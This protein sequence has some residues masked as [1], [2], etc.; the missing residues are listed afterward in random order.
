VRIR[1]DDRFFVILD[2]E[3][4]IRAAGERRRVL[5][6]GDGFGGL[7]ALRGARTTTAVVQHIRRHA[8]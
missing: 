2:E 1:E 6:P 4:E 3:N 5:A 8:R 7:A